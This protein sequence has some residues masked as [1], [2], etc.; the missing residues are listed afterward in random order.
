MG[1]CS[2]GINL[3]PNE[4]DREDPLP[5]APTREEQALSGDENEGK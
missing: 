4:P 1:K 5:R 3:S 2:V